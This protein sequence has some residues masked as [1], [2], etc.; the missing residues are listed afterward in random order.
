M[1]FVKYEYI[2]GCIFVITHPPQDPFYFSNLI[3]SLNQLLI[4]WHFFILHQLTLLPF[5]KLIWTLYCGLCSL[6]RASHTERS[7]CTISHALP[8]FSHF[9][10]LIQFIDRDS[11]IGRWFHGNQAGK[12]DW[13]IG[14]IRT[15]AQNQIWQLPQGKD[16]WRIRSDAQEKRDKNGRKEIS[17]FLD[18]QVGWITQNGMIRDHPSIF[19]LLWIFFFASISVRFLHRFNFFDVCLTFH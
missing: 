16:L 4:L 17:T 9:P 19:F 12:S 2:F 14:K 7:H 11:D 3:H 5:N 6:Q 1:D 15:W 13:R 8:N 10:P 18:M